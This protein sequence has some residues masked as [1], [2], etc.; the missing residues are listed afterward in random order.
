M[1]K[2]GSVHSVSLQSSSYDG[3]L[4]AR[5][6]THDRLIAQVRSSVESNCDDRSVLVVWKLP[7]NCQSRLKADKSS[8]NILCTV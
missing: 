7:L 4:P 5:Y 2:L 8:R 6:E 1:G 3:L